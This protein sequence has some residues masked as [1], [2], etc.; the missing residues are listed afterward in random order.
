MPTASITDWLILIASLLG[1]ALFGAATWWSFYADNG[2]RRRRCPKCWFNMK[3]TAGLRCTECGYAGRNEADLHRR[4]RRPVIGFL[5]IFGCALVGARGIDHLRVEGWGGYMP[6][7]V[8]VAL[9]DGGGIGFREAD[10]ELRRRAIDGQ[11]DPATWRDILAGTADGSP[12]APVGSPAWIGR[13]GQWAL[14]AWEALVATGDGELARGARDTILRIATSYPPE[15]DLDPPPRWPAGRAVPVGVIVREAWNVPMPMRLV[16]SPERG[17]PVAFA[18]FGPAIQQRSFT[19]DLPAMPPGRHRIQIEFEMARSLDAGT[20]WT[21]DLTTT[22]TTV[23]TVEDGEDAGD[24]DDTTDE[25]DTADDAQDATD[26]DTRVASAGSG[27]P[28]PVFPPRA[29]DASPPDRPGLVPEPV[30]DP[31]M[32]AIIS[33]VFDN[34]IVQWADGSLP[35]RITINRRRTH[36]AAMN[37]VA[38]GLEVELRRN[39]RLGRTLELWWMAG[40]VPTRANEWEVPFVDDSVLLPPATDEDR[41]ELIVRGREDLALRVPGAR[42]HWVGEFTRPVPVVLRRGMAPSRGWIPVPLPDAAVRSENAE[43]PPSDAG[44][45]RL[46]SDSSDAGASSPDAP[47]PIDHEG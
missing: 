8:H 9:L 2:R 27:D 15:I 34:G 45:T 47:G 17:R 21:G 19:L 43:S 28:A 29:D 35:V 22:V 10:A 42:Y 37:D 5:A 26:D 13:H 11:I 33:R 18:R 24:T 16:V 7:P 23:L 14:R 12:D 1:M 39:G 31:A 38:V 3:H 6:T 25:R 4:R 40:N 36:V 20:P 44:S 32:A 41:W 46:A 30:D